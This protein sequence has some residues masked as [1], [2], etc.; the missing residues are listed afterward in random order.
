MVLILS[1]CSHET[2]PVLPRALRVQL[3]VRVLLE[4]GLPRGE[5]SAENRVAKVQISA[6]SQFSVA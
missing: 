1:H 4:K 5:P 3:L 2:T 6:L